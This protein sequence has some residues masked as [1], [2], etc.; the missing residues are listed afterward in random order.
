MA[1]P[2]IYFNSI[3]KNYK[4]ETNFFV[5]I[6]IDTNNIN[7]NGLSGEI[8]LPKNLEL[9]Y[10]EDS[11][12]II[13]NWIERP[14]L[15][16]GKVTFSGITPN[17]FNGYVN[18]NSQKHEGLVLRMVL[19]SKNEQKSEIVLQNVLITKND[20][21][22]TLVKLENAKT[23]L[24]FTASGFK[25]SYSIIDTNPP[26]VFYEIVVDPNLNGGAK[27]L[28][29]NVIDNESGFKEA[30]VKEGS[31]DFKSAT[32]PYRLEDQNL[33]GIIQLRAVDNAGNITTVSVKSPIEAYL[34]SNYFVFGSLAVLL[35][36]FIIFY[37]KFKKTFNI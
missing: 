10:F 20:G 24:S 32:S 22:G 11:N 6:L 36:L 33:R 14:V 5:D 27:S 35:V 34:S 28:A 30:F 9:V 19:K 17:G 16:N 13:K 21:Q 37:A 7:I 4:P 29:F 26:Q 18:T 8:V 23:N 3:S 25:E 1:T 12:S 31:G 2:I 15:E